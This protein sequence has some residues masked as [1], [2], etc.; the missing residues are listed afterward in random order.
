MNAR[1]VALNILNEVYT[2]Q[3]YANISLS[4][5]LT[6]NQLSDQDRRFI[7]ELVYGTVKAGDTLLGF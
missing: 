7:T 6:K 3:A 2:Q 1:E 5:H 4:R